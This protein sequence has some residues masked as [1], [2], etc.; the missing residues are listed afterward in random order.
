MSTRIRGLFLGLAMSAITP[1][2]NL[3]AD[4]ILTT[5]TEKQEAIMKPQVKVGGDGS[6]M[7]YHVDAPGPVKNFYWG[8]AGA[9]CGWTYAC[10]PEIFA[11]TYEREDGSP[12]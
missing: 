4:T 10:K 3:N 11:A 7:H 6:L 5:V 8:C 2:V 12:V 1:L 9:A